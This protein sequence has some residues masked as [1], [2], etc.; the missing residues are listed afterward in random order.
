MNEDLK[1]VLDLSDQIKRRI[2]EECKITRVTLWNWANGKTPIP[3]WAME[4]INSISKE[5]LGKEV[6]AE[7]Y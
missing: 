6:F 5:I 1:T 2:I 3:F 4:K 7:E